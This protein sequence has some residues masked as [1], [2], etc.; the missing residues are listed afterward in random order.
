MPSG[1]GSWRRRE[2]HG[3]L[4]LAGCVSMKKPNLR[5]VRVA[6]EVHNFRVADKLDGIVPS[7]SSKWLPA[8]SFFNPVSLLSPTVIGGAE[9]ASPLAGR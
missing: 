3:R 5:A 2:N 7:L 9:L 4:S 1:I 8:R 6:D